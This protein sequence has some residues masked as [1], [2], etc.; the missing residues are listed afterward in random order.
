MHPTANMRH[1]ARP[2]RSSPEVENECA[3]EQTSA[4]LP[5]GTHGTVGGED[6]E[7]L[8]RAKDSLRLP[9]WG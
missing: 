3:A 9:E 7:G 4:P 5:A 2:A 1:L 6:S 8:K